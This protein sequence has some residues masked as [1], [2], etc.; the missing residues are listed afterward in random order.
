[1]RRPHTRETRFFFNLCEFFSSFFLFFCFSTDGQ[2]RP[3]VF[4]DPSFL[5]SSFLFLTFS[6]FLSFFLSFFR[7]NSMFDD[8]EKD[9][10]KLVRCIRNKF[11]RRE[12]KRT[13]TSRE[14]KNATND[15]DDDEEE[16]KEKEGG[17]S[18]HVEI[19]LTPPV[20]TP[21]T[22]THK[23]E[24]EE[25]EE[26]KKQNDIEQPSSPTQ[27]L[28]KMFEDAQDAAYVVKKDVEE[29]ASSAA[30]FFSKLQFDLFNPETREDSPAR[31][32][33]RRT[34]SRHENESDDN[35][36]EQENSHTN[37][38]IDIVDPFS[39]VS[40]AAK[41]VTD[42]ITNAFSQVTSS[43]KDEFFR[44]SGGGGN[45]TDP[46]SSLLSTEI[47]VLFPDLPADVVLVE[48]VSC[49]LMQTYTCKNNSLTPDVG[50]SFA[51]G[52]FLCDSYLCFA[53]SSTP[54]TNLQGAKVVAKYSDILSCK[55]VKELS[56]S[57]LVLTFKKGV[58]NAS[59][60]PSEIVFGR[61]HNKNGLNDA[62]SIIELKRE[63]E[64]VV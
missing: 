14:K 7:R 2:T 38:S 64:G 62:L 16:E 4:W 41:S 51:G 39:E 48:A 10:K 1:M 28:E 35:T 58:L 27:A 21:S 19:L 53:L 32:N 3:N 44:E 42:E 30:D 23:K 34:S 61:F 59:E 9:F 6:F 12:H 43:I 25:E 15:G 49:Y 63:E 11:I 18:E 37:D 33:I 46:S 29:L 26:E 50:M 17:G 60:E 54:T 20:A 8:E 36:R 5:P 31:P 56:T 13:M 40:A 57:E 45:F 22:A 55:E 24:E 52:L 47:D